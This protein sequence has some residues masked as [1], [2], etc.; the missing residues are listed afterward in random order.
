MSVLGITENAAQLFIV[1]V[2]LA[3]L[4]SLQALHSK[5]ELQELTPH[6]FELFDLEPLHLERRYLI[7]SDNLSCQPG[8]EY[9]R[10]YLPF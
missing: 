7:Y 3:P 6:L 4:A 1:E 10:I 2:R 9:I 5:N 8:M